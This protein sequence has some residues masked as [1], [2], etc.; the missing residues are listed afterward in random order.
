[1]YYVFCDDKLLNCFEYEN[2]AFSYLF[3]LKTQYEDE[4]VILE[5]Y[6]E[7]TLIYLEIV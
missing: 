1:M 6:H 7:E 2:A 5:I 3:Y 4:D